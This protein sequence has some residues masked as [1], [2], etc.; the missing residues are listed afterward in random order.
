M[1]FPAGTTSA[2]GRPPCQSPDVCAERAIEPHERSISFVVQM[3][4][5]VWLLGGDAALL[6]ALAATRAGSLGRS[7][8]RGPSRQA[9]SPAYAA[10][11]LQ[12][13]RDRRAGQDHRR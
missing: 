7:T 3:G 8:F 2:R 6:L 12:S 5:R 10:D 13:A 1:T 11:R 9:C 4:V